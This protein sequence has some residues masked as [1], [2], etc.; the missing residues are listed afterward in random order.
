MA[1]WRDAAG[2][3]RQAQVIVEKEKQDEKL[4][5]V[6]EQ[7]HDFLASDLGAEARELLKASCK[8]VELGRED[9]PGTGLVAIYSLAEWGLVRYTTRDRSQETEDDDAATV[10]INGITAQEAVDAAARLGNK[11]P[12]SLVRWLREEL[13][14][15]AAAA[16]EPAK[17]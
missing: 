8:W 2:L 1:N 11:D 3:Y 17:K 16:P 4:H 5:L 10:I 15:I 12:E 9:V 13:D 6:A 7:L 14:K